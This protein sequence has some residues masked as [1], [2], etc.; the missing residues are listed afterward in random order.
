M[1]EHIVESSEAP[2][3]QVVQKAGSTT[4]EHWFTDLQLPQV[5]ADNTHF[6]EV[7]QAEASNTSAT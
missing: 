4:V 5:V 7:Q 1:T 3:E 6:P 2:F